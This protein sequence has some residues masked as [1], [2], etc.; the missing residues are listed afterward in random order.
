MEGVGNGGG[1]GGEFFL[2]S[3]DLDYPCNQT[4][5]GRA[6]PDFVQHVYDGFS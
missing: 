1:G 5:A 2:R 6:L 4:V 3:I